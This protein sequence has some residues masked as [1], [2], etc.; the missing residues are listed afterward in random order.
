MHSAFSEELVRAEGEQDG[1]LGVGTWV[2]AEE[3]ELRSV[4]LSWLRGTQCLV[5]IA[6]MDGQTEHVVVGH[7]G[8]GMETFWTK[9]LWN[10]G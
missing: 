1:C 5:Q 10:H 8:C 6:V 7:L 9:K 2:R 3:R 4:L